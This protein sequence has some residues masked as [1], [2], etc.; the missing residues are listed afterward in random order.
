MAELPRDGHILEIGCGTGQAT[1]LFAPLGKSITCVERG[2]GLARIAEHNLK[3]F[4][5]VQ[6]VRSRFEDWQG[7]GSAFDLIISAHAFHWLERDRAL[8]KAAKLLQSS[9][10]IGLFWNRPDESDAPYRKAFD[11]AYARHAPHLSSSAADLALEEWI[12]LKKGDLASSG[13]FA[14]ASVQQYP[15]SLSYDGKRYLELIGTYSDHVLLP[16]QQRSA[17]FQAIRAEIEA[18]G[19]SIVKKYLAVLFFAKLA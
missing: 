7:P 14:P 10:G 5:N 19:G 16:E 12:E 13:L 11:E 4:P 3:A 9:G 8:V 1:A 15:W 17:L 18:L 2:E 6:I